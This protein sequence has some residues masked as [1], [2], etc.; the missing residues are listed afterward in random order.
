MCPEARLELNTAMAESV[1]FYAG[2]LLDRKTRKYNLPDNF[3]VVLSMFG[4][5]FDT[6]PVHYISEKQDL[7]FVCTA[8]IM[9]VS[10]L[11]RLSLLRQNS[12]RTILKNH[13]PQDQHLPP[14]IQTSYFVFLWIDI[15]YRVQM[16]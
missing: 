11:I 4:S 3:L 15:F 10:L 9:T 8:S 14:I 13:L 5:A 1:Q 7:I 12:S 6:P 2:Q 16:A